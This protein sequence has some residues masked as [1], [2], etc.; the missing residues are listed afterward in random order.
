[1]AKGPIQI[2]IP[3]EIITSKIYLLRNKKV[4]LDEDLAQLYNVSTGG[5]RKLDSQK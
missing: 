4:M 2:A 3:D 5:H 1:M